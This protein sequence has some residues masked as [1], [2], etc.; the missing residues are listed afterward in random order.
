MLL[1]KPIQQSAASPTKCKVKGKWS[2]PKKQQAWK[3]CLKT[4]LLV[5]ITDWLDK[6][7]HNFRGCKTCLRENLKIDWCKSN[8]KLVRL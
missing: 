2:I 4:S 8:N 7:S 6:V 1:L 3:I 5:P